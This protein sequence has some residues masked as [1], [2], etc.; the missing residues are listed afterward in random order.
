M[1]TRDKRYFGRI[2]ASNMNRYIQ[3]EFRR[4]GVERQ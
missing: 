3:A 1:G 4:L 2:R